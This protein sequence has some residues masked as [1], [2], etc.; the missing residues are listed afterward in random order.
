M[1]PLYTL[2][3]G[4]VFATTALVLSL[5]VSYGQFKVKENF[6]DYKADIIAGNGVDAG[7][8]GGAAGFATLSGL[9]F[10]SAAVTCLRNR[11]EVTNKQSKSDDIKDTFS[12]NDKEKPAI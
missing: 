3:I 12:P 1:R 9:C 10:L 7:Y 8:D 2:Y 4:F 6:G 5:E 11:Q